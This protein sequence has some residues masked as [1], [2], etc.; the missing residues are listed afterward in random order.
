MI[1]W[2][3]IDTYIRPDVLARA[4]ADV[5]SC[6]EEGLNTPLHLNFT[7]LFS[8]PLLLSIYAEELRLR[9]GVIIQR[10]PVVDGFSIN[11]FNFPKDRMIV[12]SSWHE[13]RDREVWNQGG[14]N[15][16]EVHD[17]EDFW[18]DRFV[19]YPDDPFS[20]PRK[21]GKDVKV[22]V[23]GVEDGEKKEPRYNIDSVAGSFIPYGGGKSLFFFDPQHMHNHIKPSLYIHLINLVVYPLTLYTGAKVCP[24]RF[25]AK[26]EAV[27]GLALFIT[28]FDVEFLGDKKFKPNTSFFPFGVVPPLGD[29]RVKIRRRK[30]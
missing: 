5:Q 30:V 15:G 25:Y 19:V 6:V 2:E 21:P 26:Q 8:K 1:A 14:G 10:V 27:T 11:G 23:A 28:K 16:G 13:Q 12:A 4:R 29:F 7:K 24:G 22:K 18:A 9:N 20:G 3:L 17:V